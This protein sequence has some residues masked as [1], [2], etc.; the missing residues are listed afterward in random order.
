MF[1]NAF[2]TQSLV[3]KKLMLSISYTQK[4][5]RSYITLSKLGN[6]ATGIDTQELSVVLRLMVNQGFTADK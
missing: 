4:E 2:S 6:F 3:I 5:Y 1:P